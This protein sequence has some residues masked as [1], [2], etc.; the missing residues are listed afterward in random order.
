MAF[1]IKRA[2]GPASSADGTRVLPSTIF[3]IGYEGASLEAFIARLTRGGVNLVVDVRDL[4]LS[5]KR[6]F[7]KVALSEALDSAG[8]GYHHIRELGCPKPIRDRYRADGNWER[9]TA[10]FMQHL[11][12]QKAAVEAVAQLCQGS[13]LA[14]LC[15]E[16]DPDRCHRTYVAQV[17][18]EVAGARVSPL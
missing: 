10:S 2:Y 17:A 18:A 1:M 11:S 6:G 15:Y 13:S 8:I 4:P 16:S 14:L 9:Y 3:T 5:R 12:Q 7:S